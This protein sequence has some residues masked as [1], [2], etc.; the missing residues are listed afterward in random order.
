ME[1]IT[2]KASSSEFGKVRKYLEEELGKRQ[3]SREIILET[4]LV[5]E[6]IFSNIINQVPNKTKIDVLV[7][8]SF[9]QVN[10]CF[11]YLGDMYIHNSFSD[12]ASSPEEKIIKAYD[13]KLQYSY[14]TSRNH[15]SL[16]VKRGSMKSI[17]AGAIGIV[18]AIVLCLLLRSVNTNEQ[19]TAILANYLF[20]IERAYAGL[21]LMV[22]APV[23]F[24]TLLSNL[25]DIYVFAEES[26]LSRV[27]QRRSFITS[28]ISII[29]AIGIFQIFAILFRRDYGLLS[30]YASSSSID[31]SFADFLSESIPSNF[32]D[33]FLS[34][35]PVPLIIVS[36]IVVYSFCAS[37]KYINAFKRFIEAAL[38]VFSKMINPLMYLLP[39][40]C[41][42]ATLDLII[43]SGLMV[44][45]EAFWIYLIILLGIVSML[46]FYII[47]LAIAKVEIIP[48][49]KKLIPS[50]HENI[51]IN[52]TADAVS[53]NI[54][55]CS[56]VYGI[57]RSLL[58]ESLPILSKIN[59]DGNCFIVMF[60][61]LLL[62]FFTG[63]NL[64][65]PNVLMIIFVVFFLSIGAPNP[66]GSIFIA[67]L[68]MLE[69][70]KLPEM[71]SLCIFSEILFGP[72]QNLINYI[73]DIV[74][75]AIL[76]KEQSKAKAG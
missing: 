44:L 3:I 16:S 10:I 26:S 63:L 37:G 29:L 43:E 2:I 17:L 59:L 64:S 69:M 33:P 36:L 56:R 42:L 73:G 40:F 51:I 7:K 49:I 74:T 53:Y 58:D 57:K 38:N 71:I 18:S 65:L 47:R 13:D 5:F 19:N 72:V 60:N 28:I 25:T 15:I 52:S 39:F 4:M 48:F 27:L 6:A 9:G 61:A 14:H 1:S 23:T 24:L 22:G 62:A 54:R 55:Y 30:I 8:N 46:I 50:I 76:E 20:P 41:F 34:S 67:T 35:S 75:V 31:L 12:D 70:L 32:F 21:L 66:P 45:I 68:I 11:K